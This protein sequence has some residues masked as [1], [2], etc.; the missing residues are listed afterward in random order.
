MDAWFF[1][2]KAM[3]NTVSLMLEWSH[4]FEGARE[5]DSLERV[6]SKGAKE[7]LIEQDER[8]QEYD[9]VSCA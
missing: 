3:G 5:H 9:E 6:T 4:I 7:N 2:C 1:N 8:V